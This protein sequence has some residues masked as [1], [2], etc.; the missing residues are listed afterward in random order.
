MTH[1]CTGWR[2]VDSVEQALRDNF[3]IPMAA[4]IERVQEQMRSEGITEAGIRHA[5]T[6]LAPHV[7]DA[8]AKA[9]EQIAVGLSRT[10]TKH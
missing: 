2:K 5:M 7:A 6:L 8:R 9:E 4:E 10:A 3:D 1:E